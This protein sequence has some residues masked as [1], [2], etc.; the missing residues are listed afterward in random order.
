MRSFVGLLKKD[1]KG[2][3]DQPTG[4]VLLIIFVGLVGYLFFRSAL[5]REEASVRDIFVTMPWVLA[6]IVPA[7]TMRLLAEEQRDGTLEI[8]LTQPIRSSQLLL[9]KFSAAFL[10]IGL[11]IVLTAGIPIALM[12]AGNL[13]EGA[14]VAQYLGTLFLAASF[15]AIGL[16]TSGLTQ[17]QVVAFI[18]GLAFTMGLT[19]AGLPLVTVAIPQKI[20]VL[21]QDL[22][23][24]THY[25]VIVRGA[26]DLRDVLYFVAIVS[27]FISG[28]YML[29]RGKSISHRSPHYLNLRLGV[30]ALV[31]LGLLVG[32]LGTSI[33]GR[34]DLTENRLYTL[35]G[36]S[37]DLLANLD[38]VVILKLFVS[39][40]PPAALSLT[41]RDVTDF[42][43][44]VEAASDGNVRV[45][46]KHPDEGEEIADEA[47]RNFVFP[48]EYNVQS[49]GEFSVQLAWLGLSMT[50]A[51]RREA[52]PFI[53]S[54]DS[55]EPL[56]ISG[57]H[58][59]SKKE[60][61]TVAVM[62]DH[63]ERSIG[64][65]LQSFRNIASTAH[66]L[67]EITDLEGFI[68][69]EA[70]DVLVVPGPTEI[71][72]PDVYTAMHNFLARGGKAMLLLDAVTINQEQLSAEVNGASMIDFLDDYGI[73]IRHDLIFDKRSSQNLQFTSRFGP[74]SLR[75][76]YWP[77]VRAVESTISGGV[78]EI[79]MPWASS[80][81]I[82][83]EGDPSLDAEIQV[84]LRTSQFAVLDEA[85][86]D[87]DPTSPA[88]EFLPSDEQDEHIVGVAISGTRCLTYEPDCTK[89]PDKPFRLIVMGD[90]D[91]MTEQ[92]VGR[93]SDQVVLGVNYLD[94][95]AQDDAL[96][97]I[98]AKQSASR[99]LLFESD[100]HRNAVQYSNMIGLPVLFAL[101]GLL[102]L[103]MR[104]RAQR[105][106]YTNE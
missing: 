59:M 2:Y 8:L 38:D 67:I 70:V 49:A 13:D 25:G 72:R 52:L 97:G 27:V 75:Y 44:D 34:L 19:I 5:V 77:R 74:V 48:I 39:K 26:L 61:K 84:L 23:P 42:I 10:F 12:S 92:M 17:N 40:D 101:L 89:D 71:I 32:W 31:V 46:T 16:F 11:A 9:A 3:F 21:V 62:T 33:K 66:N 93:N 78:D 63:G 102:R 65:E 83:K 36:A 45:I 43:E 28:T 99:T 79:I 7:A 4:Y 14:V 15:V 58:R 76:P 103:A 73:E 53:S 54:V 29:L 81:G 91:W 88:L 98:R 94:W 37:K 64:Q 20:A 50:Y 35:S 106:I 6:V 82:K 96:A 100:F 69:L 60:R 41:A 86:I 47:A 51:N 68:E 56:L 105:K 80:I 18:V 24:L 30:V 90:S 104:R 95:L 1:L 87:L 22:S 55:L 57:I 85:F